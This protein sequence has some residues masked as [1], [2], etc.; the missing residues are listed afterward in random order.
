LSCT[1]STTGSC[2]ATGSVTIPAGNFIDFL[3]QNA[4]GTVAGVWTSL[5]CQ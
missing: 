4:S 1:P 2:P 3:I 5:Q